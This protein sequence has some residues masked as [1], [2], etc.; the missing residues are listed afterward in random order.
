MAFDS[1]PFFRICAAVILILLSALYF[2][3][4]DH[5]ADNTVS[6][7]S[8]AVSSQSFSEDGAGVDLPLP[9]QFDLD[10]SEKIDSDPIFLSAFRLLLSSDDHESLIDLYDQIYVNSGI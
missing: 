2:W 6:L 5:G 3:S 9:L 8:V 4:S 7:G 1:I 10:L